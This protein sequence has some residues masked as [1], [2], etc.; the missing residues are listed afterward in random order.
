[1]ESNSLY[2]CGICYYQS[3]AKDF[4]PITVSADFSA[5]ECPKCLNNDKDQFTEITIAVEQAA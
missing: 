4:T 5:L 3:R 1:M 2:E